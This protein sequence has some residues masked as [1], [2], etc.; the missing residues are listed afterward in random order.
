MSIQVSSD[1][2]HTTE[3]TFGNNRAV[4]W[5]SQAGC[6]AGRLD[7]Q[8]AVGYEL[9]RRHVVLST[10]DPKTTFQWWSKGNE[11]GTY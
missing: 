9:N 3:V 5:P 2:A 10:S 6:W 7:G 11:H 8:P 4:P 1:G